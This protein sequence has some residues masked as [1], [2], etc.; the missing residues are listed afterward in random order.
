MPRQEGSSERKGPRNSQD[1]SG[2]LADP[3]STDLISKSMKSS[4]DLN[5]KV[6][7]CVLTDRISTLVKWSKISVET[8]IEEPFMDTKHAPKTMDA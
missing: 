3:I 2:A 8:V 7:E 5:N 6:Q 4:E 1:E